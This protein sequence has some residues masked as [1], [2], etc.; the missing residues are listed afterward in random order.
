MIPDARLGSSGSVTA[1]ATTQEDFGSEARHLSVNVPEARERAREITESWKMDT[2]AKAI[3]M[4]VSLP[5]QD[6]N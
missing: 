6:F 2:N 5:L 3:L 1:P 4:F